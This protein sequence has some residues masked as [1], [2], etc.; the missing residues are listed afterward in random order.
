MD[1]NEESF[2]LLREE[3]SRSL[4]LL[5]KIN[6]THLSRLT[7]DLERHISGNE[8]CNNDN[9][10]LLIGGL[11]RSTQHFIFEGKDGV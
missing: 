7:S 5:R 8:H 3:F 11:N 2:C 10:P 9:D 1:Q 6:F 4:A